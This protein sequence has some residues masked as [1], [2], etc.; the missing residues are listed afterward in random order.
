MV[1]QRKGCCLKVRPQTLL[2]SENSQLHRGPNQF[3]CEECGPPK[4]SKAI[5]LE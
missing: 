5:V 3:P 4:R 1:Y 2:L